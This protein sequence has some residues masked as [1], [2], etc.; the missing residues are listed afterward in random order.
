MK[1]R[2]KIAG[3]T[4]KINFIRDERAVSPIIGFM[5]VLV[6]VVG[7]MS[8]IQVRHVPVWNQ[9]VE[10]K[11]VNVVYD[12]MRVLSTDISNVVTSCVPKMSGLHLGVEY[13][14]RGVFY[15][16]TD[17]MVGTLTINS[18]PNAVRINYT[19][20]GDPTVYNFTSDSCSLIYKAYG[21][22]PHATLVYEH[23]III[24]DYGVYG[25][26][27]ECDQTMI[28]GDNI[29][30]PILNGTDRVL[31]SKGLQSLTTF[32]Y[33]ETIPKT[34]LKY[35]NITLTTNYPDVWRSLLAGVNT[36]KTTAYVVGNEIHIDSFANSQGYFPGKLLNPVSSRLYAGMVEFSQEEEIWYSGEGEGTI[37]GGTIWKNIPSSAEITEMK[38]TSIVVDLTQDSIDE[39]RLD[40]DYIRILVTDYKDDWWTATIN[41]E[42]DK[43]EEPDRAEIEEIT[44][45]AKGKAV[46]TYLYKNFEFNTSTIIDL[47]NETNYDKPDSCYRN[48]NI[49]YINALSSEVGDSDKSAK[50]VAVKYCQLITEGT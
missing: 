23:G 27:T 47:L 2:G 17:A 39:E 30:I 50:P 44:A 13:P 45:E 19:K 5:F 14:S 49:S 35:V 41:F 29:Y 40:N 37:G 4:R 8:T 26:A 32:P 3:G 31:T 10:F 7:I 24:R 21:T 15:N 11:H 25:N 9:G 42:W 6:I 28:V 48:A 12:E 46:S 38:V 22:V 1:K 16:P 20:H 43:T 33:T 18:V 34:Q 36:S